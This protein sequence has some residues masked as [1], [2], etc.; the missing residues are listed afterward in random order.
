M[1]DF[2]DRLVQTLGGCARMSINPKT[3]WISV[4]DKEHLQAQNPGD[5]NE[6]TGTFRMFG[7]FG[8]V[9][10]KSH[11]GIKPGVIITSD[12]ESAK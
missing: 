2:E 4:Q 10:L 6:K 7:P 5:Y 3:M 9:T 12:F 8:F 11:E 1:S